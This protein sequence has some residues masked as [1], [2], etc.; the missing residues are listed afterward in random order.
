MMSMAQCFVG[1]ILPPPPPPHCPVYNEQWCIPFNPFIAETVIRRQNLDFID[2]KFWRLIIDYNQVWKYLGSNWTSNFHPLEVVDLGSIK[3]GLLYGDTGEAPDQVVLFTDGWPRTTTSLITRTRLCCRA[4]DES[5]AGAVINCLIWPP[6][7]AWRQGVCVLSYTS[8][9][10][11]AGC[12]L[13]QWSI[14][15]TPLGQRVPLS[16]LNLPLSSSSTISR[17]LLSQ[18]STCS[19]WRWLE[20]GD[21]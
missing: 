5:E 3:R 8:T 14:E 19:R 10:P 11:S 7:G 18:F 21:K 13:T 12:R 16:S 15:A 1:T 20:W 2:V 6:G 4:A 9:P 17:E